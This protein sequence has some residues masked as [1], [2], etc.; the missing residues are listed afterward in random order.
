MNII[1][2]PKGQASTDIPEALRILADS[3]EAG[4]HGE[5]HN[6]AWVLDQGDF[7]IAVGLLGSVPGLPGPA[8]HL[9]FC[10]GQRRLEG[11]E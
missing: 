3:I 11:I 4:D 2:F 7:A 1:T 5:V 10:L 8:A 9:L 6:L